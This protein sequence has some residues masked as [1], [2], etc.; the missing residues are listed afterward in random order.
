MLICI[1]SIRQRTLLKKEVLSELSYLYEFKPSA[2]EFN[3]CKQNATY[4]YNIFNKDDR[5]W[6]IDQLQ[7]YTKELEAKP[8][9]LPY[10]AHFGRR[11]KLKDLPII[12]QIIE[13]NILRN[14]NDKNENLNALHK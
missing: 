7:R 10:G 14:H 6:S 8:I 12:T 11:S 3:I 4:R 1:N 13:Q 5:I 2:Q 9:E